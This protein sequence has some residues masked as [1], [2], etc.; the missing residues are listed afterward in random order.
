MTPHDSSAPDPAPHPISGRMRQPLARRPAGLI[1]GVLGLLVVLLTGVGLQL[2]YTRVQQREG[3]RIE[4]IVQLRAEQL[5]LWLAG[6]TAAVRFIG[7]G[8]FYAGLYQRHLAGEHQASVQMFERLEDFRAANQFKTALLVDAQA[9]PVQ[10]PRAAP[11]GKSAQVERPGAAQEAISPALRGAAR[12][13]MATGQVVRTDLHSDL[14]AQASFELVSPIVRLGEPALAAIVMEIDAQDYLL[15]TVQRWPLPSR[16]TSA[17]LVRQVGDE[18]QGVFDSTRVALNT[19]ND[20]AARIVRGQDEAGHAIA[21][22]DSSGQPVFGTALPISGTPWWMVAHIDRSELIELAS[23]EALWIVA[24]ALLALFTLGV[25]TRLYRDHAALQQAL[26]EQALQRERLDALTLIDAI[27][28]SSTD[29]IFAKDTQ[30]R[31]LLFNRAASVATGK[32]AAEVIG[33]DDHVLFKPADARRI[34]DN[35]A[36]VMADNLTRSFEEELGSDRGN[37]V[38]LSTKGPLH[39]PQGRVIGL[40][41]ISRD[42]SERRRTDAALHASQE[43]LRLFVEHAPAAIAML[44]NSLR[45]LAVSRRWS[46]DFKVQERLDGRDIVG[47]SHDDLFPELP[48]RWREVL[49]R[50]LAG[51]VEPAQVDSVLRPDGSTDWVRWE[52]RPWHNEQ[53]SVGGVFLLSEIITERVVADRARAVSEARFR[54]AFEQSAVGMSET[55]LD[56]QWIAV[57]QRLCQITGYPREALLLK[58]FQDLTHPED[59][60][61][62]LHQMQRVL[63]GELDGFTIEKRYIR[64]DAALI[65]VRISTS[66][67]RDEQGGEPLYFVA[68]IEEVTTR[69]QA[70][71]ALAE[72]ATVLQ[73]VEDSILDHL[74]VLDRDGC[75]V[76]VN[77]AWRRFGQANT[78]AAASVDIDTGSETHD[79]S[80]HGDSDA[81]ESLSLGADVGDSYLGVCDAAAGP[82]SQGAAQAGAGIRAVLSGTAASY[83]S[84]YAC[85][86]PTQPR[87]FH[88]AVTPLHTQGG[89]AVVVHTDITAR[90]HEQEMLR[91]SEA[92]Y[93]S[94]VSAL[95][96][97][98]LVHDGVGRLVA[99]NPSAER[100]L[101]MDLA[102]LRQGGLELWQSVRTDGTPMPAHEQPL[103]R[104]LQLGLPSHNLVFGLIGPAS[105]L[106]WLLVNAEPMHDTPDNTLAEHTP[107]SHTPAGRCS[108]VVISFTDIT[109]RHIAERQL[110]KLS[111]AVE[112]SPVGIVITDV[113]GRIEYVNPAYERAS[114]FSLNEALG[115]NSRIVQSG[116]TPPERY[117]QLWDTLSR[118]ETWRGEFVNR[119]KSGEL[120]QES[121]TIVPLR[122]GDGHVSHYL[123]ISEDITERKRLAT[124]LDRHRL[125]LE[126]LVAERTGELARLNQALGRERDRA[127]A[128][129]RAKSI[130]LA[131]MS[132]EIRTPMNAIIGLTHLLQRDARDPGQRERLGR[133]ASAAQHLLAV[134]NDIL[135]LSKIESGKLELEQADVNIDLLLA[136]ACALVAERARAKGLELVLDAAGLPPQLRGDPTRLSQALVNLLSNAVKFTEQGSVLLRAELVDEDEARQDR[137]GLA[138]ADTDADKDSAGTLDDAEP[139][140]VSVRFSVIDTGIGVPPGQIG[141]LFKAF[142]Q[143]DDSTTRRYGGT[144]LGLVITR[145]LAELMGGTVGVCSTPGVGS[146]FWFSA[147]M[148][149]PANLSVG[150][151]RAALAYLRTVVVDDL[152]QARSAL[153]AQLQHMGLRVEQVGDADAALA[154][155]QA[156]TLALD[157]VRLW[158][159]DAHLA[160]IDGPTLLE[161]LARQS[162]QGPAPAVLLASGDEEALHARLPSLGN[163]TTLL[164]KPV[165]SSQLFEQIDQLL[166]GSLALAL[167]PAGAAELQ[168]LQRHVGARVLLAEDNPV[169]RDVAVEL[170]QA[171]GLVVELA[172]DGAQ[173]VDLASTRPYQLVLMDMQM[174]VID[175]LQATRRIRAQPDRADLP[176]LAMTANAF[177]EDRAACLGAGMNDHIGKPVDPEL[178]YSVLLHWLDAR[179]ATSASA[180]ASATST[181]GQAAA[182]PAALSDRSGTPALVADAAPPPDGTPPQAAPH[183]P[184]QLPATAAA[185]LQVAG[186]DDQAVQRIYRGRAAMQR[187]A[188]RVFADTEGEQVEQ[189]RVCLGEGRLADARARLH[190]LRG[191]CAMV[192]ASGLQARILALEQTLAAAD[193]AVQL[194]SGAL[195]AS[196][197]ELHKQLSALILAVQAALGPADTSPPLAAAGDDRSAHATLDQLDALLACGDFDAGPALRAADALLRARLGP[198]GTER[199]HTLVRNFE[200]TQALALLRRLRSAGQGS[201][202][203]GAA[204]THP[205]RSQA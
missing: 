71:A 75:I 89:G 14:S 18:L 161:H 129:S 4:A 141:R 99:C 156:A 153:A 118:G 189:L 202:P 126:D 79:L 184:T 84:E 146:E 59:L 10:A 110:R 154:L 169:N 97:S 39:D 128:A 73:A 144:G 30:G 106:L 122:H 77:A 32:T 20:L 166:R 5:S 60:D 34:M 62:D 50:A 70:E 44:D 186:L 136:R 151:E 205:P 192:G 197:R 1:A 82:S 43:R 16:T 150:P 120:Y 38:W 86:S 21:A 190:A 149:R 94:M 81:A 87:W 188:L 162:P 13:A 160:G 147:R 17:R 135:D 31:Y 46:S 201:S 123:A 48:Q 198:H 37:V 177:G 3:V 179:A 98:V 102:E 22:L 185:L 196:A 172:E 96:E 132:H 173:A 28:E 112:Q 165:S 67:V 29:T 100:L 45:Y 134:I 85:H 111:L 130:F 78:Q 52:V 175:G 181:A 174:P 103:Q 180:S 125:H 193:G 65:W 57:N 121:S 155:A 92:R 83:S 66:L 74:A 119:R 148:R 138:F 145:H 164:L 12:L 23:R 107:V 195:D 47:L 152:A 90:R 105:Q 42:I 159:V 140:H 178:L 7:S 127:E 171:A 40:F 15:P 113:Q 199:L 104:A 200:H 167:V 6:Q 58:R 95:S 55:T 131:N 72:S 27:S 76:A 124:E 91:V 64:A 117:A 56:G 69:R 36:Q 11:A 68:V 49:G 109:E 63:A 115:H 53:G 51:V 158:I 35:D 33:R 41:G 80:T 88:M 19:P 133:V 176:I 93:R 142:E 101:G 8:P 26:H 25:A 9:Q 24:A 183:T 204:G 203:A 187:H 163:L 108:G 143:A 170:L 2:H 191:A 194:G 168:L 61:S 139:G 182:D 157:P 137:P 114:G 54:A 116:R